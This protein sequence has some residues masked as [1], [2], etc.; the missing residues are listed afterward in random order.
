MKITGVHEHAEYYPMLSEEQLEE[1]A[2]DIKEN[3]QRDPITVTSDGILIDGRN[4]WEACKRLGIEPAIEIEDP[5]DVG[6][7]VRSRNERRH[8]PTG[9]RAMSTA[10]SLEHDGKRTVDK[11]GNGRWAQGSMSSGN[12]PNSDNWASHMRRAGLIIDFLP[13]LAWDV[14]S[15]AIRL[16]DAYRQ[17]RDERDRRKSEAEKKEARKKRAMEEEAYAA[18][19]FANDP[20]AR[21]WLEEKLG[22]GPAAAWLAGAQESIYATKASAYSSYET[23]VDEVRAAEDARREA[24]RKR[25]QEHR[26]SIQRTKS[27]L[28]AWLDTY[29][30]AWDMRTNEYRDE[31]LSALETR[32][33]NR[34]LTI[35]KETTWPTEII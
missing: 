12:L 23:E 33:R 34:F 30:V 31:I 15:G 26:D 1:L 9:S 4:R 5:K 24:E 11:A 13:D 8:Q 35:E 32:N 2:A 14:I 6:A 3:G 16:D 21:A 7:F 27:R 17:A 25:L 18:D 10:L 28:E 20:D 29:T 22:K 19:K